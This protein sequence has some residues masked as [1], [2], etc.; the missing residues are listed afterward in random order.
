MQALASKAYGQVT[1]R[2]AN[3]RS[4]EYALF[5]QITHGLEEVAASAV[6][7]H[8]TIADAVYRNAQLWSTLAA[9]LLHP[10]NALPD[11]TR[12]GLLGLSEFVRRTSQQ[13]LAGA[14]GIDDLIEINRTIMP[15]LV[16]PMAG[17]EGGEI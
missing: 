16:R 14:G 4:L 8:G 17:A 1:Q 7:A 10:D 2:T 12:A 11:E 3:G 9:D 15:G 6:P 13:I 5:E